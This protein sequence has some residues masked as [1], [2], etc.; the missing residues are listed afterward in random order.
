MPPTA[1]LPFTAAKLRKR[2]VQR[3][4]AD[5]PLMEGVRLLAAHTSIDGHLVDEAG[6]VIDESSGSSTSCPERLLAPVHFRS[7]GIQDFA[8]TLA[9]TYQTG[10]EK[11]SLFFVANS[12]VPVP[13]VTPDRL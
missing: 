9:G 7:S 8:R 11:S 12:F 10:K 13:D 3:G 4:E 1:A 2:K 6:R 5:V